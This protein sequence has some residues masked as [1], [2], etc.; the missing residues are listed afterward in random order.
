MEK[1]IKGLIYI[2]VK[3]LTRICIRLFYRG[4]EIKGR[5]NL[6]KKGPI[7]YAVNH[8][9]AF[10]DA[11]IVGGIS[12][13]PT[14]FMTRSDIFKPPFDWILDALKM[15]PIYRIRDGYKNL[16]KNDH[17]FNTCKKLLLDEQAILIFPEGN[18]GL[19]YYLRPLTKG[20][21]RIGLQTQVELTEAISIIPVG[22][23]YFNHFSSGHKLIVSY[24]KP[25]VINDFVS[26]Y[27][28]H[29]HKGLLQL[30]RTISAGMK[31]TL[32][33]PSEN[34][35]YLAEKTVFQRKNESRNFDELKELRLSTVAGI[36]E[37]KYPVAASIGE[38]LG[39]FN[40]PPLYLTKYILKKKVTQ[41]IFTASIKFASLLIL[42]PF[43]FLLCFI[44]AGF[45]FSWKW[46]I[47]L[48]ITQIITLLIR[49][50]LV[51]YN[52]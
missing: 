11:V 16:S 13:I 14:Y 7:I 48:F 6:P 8:Q 15:M 20:I 43:W 44:T 10:L 5:E 46:A 23:N 51:R 25:I 18:H 47:G 52:H 1:R 40:F 31:E 33:I 39:I 4:V 21:S 32:I 26:A 19:E 50:E 12:P 41:K 2:Y 24:G 22:L 49:R 34:E 36:K 45:I 42:F 17:V 9:N 37:S 3:S 29:S 38:L 28:E 35:N 30:T 27:E